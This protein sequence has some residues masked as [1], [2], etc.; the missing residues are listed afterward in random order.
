MPL[1]GIRSLGPTLKRRAIDVLAIFDRPNI[2]N[3]PTEAINGRLEHRCGS[4][5]GFRNLSEVS[6]EGTPIH[7]CHTDQPRSADR[8]SMS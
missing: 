6:P 4:A 1:V 3:G 7:T 2:S 5:L 8:S